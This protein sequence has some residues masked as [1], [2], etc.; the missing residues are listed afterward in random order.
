MG[1]V[2]APRS[3]IVSLHVVKASAAG[4]VP[5]P[6]RTRSWDSSRVSAGSW[7]PLRVLFSQLSIPDKCPFLWLGS[8]IHAFLFL[9]CAVL[10]LP[11]LAAGNRLQDEKEL[12]PEPKAGGQ[13]DTRAAVWE[14]GDKCSH[15]VS[16]CFFRR[17]V[18][19]GLNAIGS[20]VGRDRGNKVHK[21]HLEIMSY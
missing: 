1:S 17:E 20:P 15:R 18:S 4:I 11:G 9:P 13:R 21:G 5:V 3:T 16:A 10:V 7:V 19:Q 14:Q 12:N 8:R 2:V 6:G